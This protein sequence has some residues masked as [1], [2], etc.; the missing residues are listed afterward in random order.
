MLPS[1][2]LPAPARPISASV[3]HP[4]S[5]AHTVS[6]NAG[7][8]TRTKSNGIGLLS[9]VVS[10]VL[11]A[12]CGGGSS[13]TVPPQP[14]AR[15]LSVNVNGN[16]LITSQPAGINCGSECEASFS[17]GAVVTLTAT[18]GTRQQLTSWS[19]ACAGAALTCTVTLREARTV[20]ASFS[21]SADV[22]FPLT[23]STTGDGRVTS[24]PAGIDCGT[25]CS[26]S[27][28]AS[29]LVTLTAASGAGYVFD[30]WS[31]A[32]SGTA[33]TCGVN[34]IAAR[35]VGAALRASAPVSGWGALVRLAGA[36]ASSPVVVIDNNDRATAVW[37]R[38]QA[39]TTE[40]HVWASRSNGGDTWS[41][42]V[43]L[44]TNVGNVT[45]LRLS[46]DRNSGFGMLLWTQTGST[47]DLHARALDP[48]NGWGPEV[49]VENS[50]G[51]VGESTVGVDAA[52]NAV[53][54]WSQIGPATRF[55][56]YASRY[57][58]GGGWGTPEL[59]ESN[60]VVGSVDGDPIVG[61]TPSGEALVVWKRSG[62]GGGNG[63]WSNRFAVGAGWATASQVVADA[64]SLQ[65]IG[66]HDLAVAGNTQ[67]LL[68]W[69][70]LDI[71]G[72]TGNNG[73]R[74]KRYSAGAWSLA[75]S[76]VTAA[77][78]NNQGFISTP[79]LR[80]NAGGDTALAWG[81]FDN[82][83]RVATATAGADFTNVTTVRAAN[84]GTWLGL[85]ALG[86][87]DSRNALIAWADPVSKDA[88]IARYTVAGG[89]SA[90][91]AN[92]NYPDQS[93]PPA[94]AMN[95]RGNAVMGWAQFFSSVGDEI[96]L[97]RYA[98]GR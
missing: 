35:S 51:V 69:G 8:A 93:N 54:V 79:V 67:A 73:I 74:F 1:N 49:R 56:I 60:E 25:A 44:E 90:A 22:R 45:R 61:V 19:G 81:E 17:D 32:C 57:M 95:E 41:A 3:E 7:N 71:S 75:S 94:L 82:S 5:E 37:L 14:N 48:V 34:V 66:R 29:T 98:S 86:I 42:P 85:P 23:V 11:L 78:P 91:A 30:G 84:S 70:Q 28:D 76:A 9:V 18:P 64:G 77:V 4:L 59:L 40:N 15:A 12:A 20:G 53:A 52:G 16:G 97:R 27:Y 92:E 88:V 33:P 13:S 2:C 47:Q 36:G 65:S 87:D 96:V 6:P 68:A 55:S 80:A 50:A 31:G 21:P 43:R 26:A 83:L 46:I 63:L 38:L 62:A 39:G 24:A 89:W 10:V 58:R 72:G